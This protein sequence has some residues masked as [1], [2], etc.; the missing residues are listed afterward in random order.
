MTHTSASSPQ[1]RRAGV[2]DA[3]TVASLLHDF[4]TEYGT[5]VPEV[6]VLGERFARLLQRA[7]VLVQFAEEGGAAI[8]FAFT[9]VRP[10]A[11]C[12]TGV[13]MLEEL[14]VQPHLRSRGAGAA[15]VDDLLRRMRAAGVDE[16]QVNVDSIDTDARRFYE[17]HGFTNFEG[18]DADGEPSQ[19]LLYVL[20]SSGSCGRLDP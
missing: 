6:D 10:S 13:A 1:V 7:D 18:T 19:L 4:N 3:T 17:R 15:M 20:P 2:A 16:V 9:T 8:G 14:Y 5:P 12:D 11:Y